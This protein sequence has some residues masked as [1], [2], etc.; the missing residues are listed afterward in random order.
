[1]SIDFFEDLRP[2][3]SSILLRYNIGGR[4]YKRRLNRAANSHF[5]LLIKSSTQTSSSIDTSLQQNEGFPQKDYVPP[6][7]VPGYLVAMGRSH[8]GQS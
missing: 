2:V 6:A 3:I 1:M 7:L 8:G 5:C 4:G